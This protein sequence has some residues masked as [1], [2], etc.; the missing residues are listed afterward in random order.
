MRSHFLLVLAIMMIGCTKAIAAEPAI[1]RYSR[2]DR[3]MADMQHVATKTDESA[4]IRMVIGGDDGSFHV[5][6]VADAPMNTVRMKGRYLDSTLT[7]AH[8]E[9]TY[10][11]SNGRKESNGVFVNGVKTGLWFRWSITGE[12]V[13]TKHYI[14]LVGDALNDHLGL[15]RTA[16]T[17]P[18]QIRREVRAMGF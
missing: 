13:A 15:S 1:V 12:Q 6:I 18:P 5:C 17:L 3:L 11:H 16:P 9:F 10:Y 7:V 2:V 8:G 4:F 14:G